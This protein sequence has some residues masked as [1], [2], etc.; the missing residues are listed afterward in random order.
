MPIAKFIDGSVYV[1]AGHFQLSALPQQ[2]VGIN[3]ICSHFEQILVFESSALILGSFQMVNPFTMRWAYKQSEQVG[4]MLFPVAGF[5]LKNLLSGSVSAGKL[6]VVGVF[7]ANSVLQASEPVWHRIINIGH[8]NLAVEMQCRRWVFLQPRHNQWS[9][10]NALG[11]GQ[12]CLAGLGLGDQLANC[13]RQYFGIGKSTMLSLTLSSP[14]KPCQ[15]ALTSLSIGDGVHACSN[16]I[17]PLGEAISFFQN[18][19]M[20]LSSPNY[21]YQIQQNCLSEDVV[22]GALKVLGVLEGV[23]K[24]YKNQK[25][26]VSIGNVEARIATTSVG[27]YIDG[28][29]I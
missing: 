18:L 24:Q 14:I 29:L 6:I 5:S 20:N 13:L 22:H 12:L 26:M 21:K 2:M 27:L 23:N 3:C 11:A 10:V 7:E 8:F 19:T 15:S 17:L 25:V 9:T 4:Q 1:N 28:R 16:I